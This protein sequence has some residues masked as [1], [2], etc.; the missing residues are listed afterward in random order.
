M[1]GFFG[2]FNYEKAGPGISKNAPPKK[3]IVVF[4]DLLGRKFWKLIQLNLLYLLFCL[5]VVTIGPATA[6]FVYILRNFI[7]ER[8]VFLFHDFLE[9]F[10]KNFKQS[11]VMGI[12]DALFIVLISVAYQMYNQMALSNAGWYIPLIICISIS[13]VF[14]IMH[15]YIYLMIVTLEL[16]LKAIL[17]NALYLSILGIKSNIMTLLGLFLV[18]IPM[19]LFWPYTVLLIPF[20]PLSLGMLIICF[21]SY[22]IIQKYVINPFYESNGVEN[23]DKP[24]VPEQTKEVLFEDMGGKELPIKAKPVIRG[25]KI[26]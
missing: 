16:K 1:A 15:F 11:F 6:G 23:P 2:L 26:R 9:A 18:F 14:V 4:F 24:V 10:K 13:I 19:F 3:R 21:N 12:I 5:P 25:K 17:K 8:P 7:Q 20:L 22:P